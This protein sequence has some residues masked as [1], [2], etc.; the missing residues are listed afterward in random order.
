[1]RSKLCVPFL[2]LPLVAACAGNGVG[3]S[4][5]ERQA[6]TDI[7]RIGEWNYDEL[8]Q[9]GDFRSSRLMGATALGENGEEIGEIENV[10]INEQNQIAALIAEVGGTWDIGDTHVAVPWQ[11]A[12]MT[13]EGV[14]IPVREDNLEQ[15]D[16]FGDN[17]P[18]AQE[19]IEQPARVVEDAETGPRTWRLTSLLGDYASLEDSSRYGYVDEVI[20]SQDGKIQAVVIESGGA[21][22]AYPFPGWDQGWQ[23]GYDYYR[24]PFERRDVDELKP[25]NFNQYPRL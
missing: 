6:D 15:Y 20:F 23:P 21:P 5:V 13:D 16:L 25:F 8:Y 12:D 1:M 22:Y 24:L 14:E 3:L 11:E 17:S 7:E 10:I 2:V 19:D 9:T 18:I 4:E